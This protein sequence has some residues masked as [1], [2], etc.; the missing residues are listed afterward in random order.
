MKHLIIALALAFSLA[1]HAAG[2]TP[3]L[4]AS[5]RA[6]P[7][8]WQAWQAGQP[9]AGPD[10][11]IYF[12]TNGQDGF[13][14]CC[15]DAKT[16]KY[17]RLFD[18]GSLAPNNKRAI[19]IAAPPAVD[20]DGLVWLGMQAYLTADGKRVGRLIAISPVDGTVKATAELPNAGIVGLGV[21]RARGRLLAITTDARLQA[22]A[23][24]DA[25]W[26]DCGQMPGAPFKPAVFL[27]DGGAV[28]AGN[29]REL[30]HFNAATDAIVKLTLPEAIAIPVSLQAT[31]D[32]K[33][34]YGVGQQGRLLRLDVTNDVFSDLGALTPAQQPSFAVNADGTVDAV[35][36][37]VLTY[38]GNNTEEVRSNEDA[39]IVRRFDPKTGKI[40]VAGKLAPPTGMLVPP[41]TNG[42]TCLGA[43]GR[44]YLLANNQVGVSLYAYPPLPE[45]PI[46]STCDR[47][48]ACRH[49]TDKD[50]V[51]DGALN[52]AAWSDARKM[53]GF[54]SG[55]YTTQVGTPKYRTTAW[56]AW[57]DTK[58]YFAARCMGDGFRAYGAFRD[59]AIW[60]AECA[61]LFLV[62]R[63]ADQPYYEIEINPH[64]LMYDCKMQ[65]FAWSEMIPHLK[66]WAAAWN[67]ATVV[68]TQILRD[69]EKITGWTM[70]LAIPFA[71]LGGA[72]KAGDT[73][74]FNIPRGA[75]PANGPE[76]YQTLVPTYADFHKPHQYP[77]LQFVK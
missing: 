2:E 16:Q 48:F 17:T 23:I 65:T 18:A 15:F 44:V 63:S 56:M 71:D 66:E 21:D 45:T 38:L 4:L 60:K 72:P 28:I 69:G 11:K 7:T 76:E 1:V 10:G 46:W 37:E 3:R 27:P 58:L 31:S 6:L 55:I 42:R 61:E 67:P 74:L 50:I 59:D 25:A 30:Y 35:T 73:W 77:K 19:N 20:A 49:L 14:L 5:L 34:V 75:F 39:G 53:D 51:I 54:K 33:L 47:V 40:A 13:W 24:K 8:L 32:G 36:G 43:D 64:G 26:K 70:E 9:A 62:P 22:Y 52:E 12:T 57:S 68:K 29:G 41:G